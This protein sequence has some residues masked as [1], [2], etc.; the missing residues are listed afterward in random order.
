MSPGLPQTSG[1][2]IVD[3]IMQKH[4]ELSPP[5]QQAV[6]LS[7]IPAMA[8]TRLAPTLPPSPEMSPPDSQAI[9]A[10]AQTTLASPSKVRGFGP[11]PGTE[12][13]E[14]L[15]M[16]SPPD[17]GQ[18]TPL[19][20][21]I[22]RGVSLGGLPSPSQARGFG[23][24]PGSPEGN[25]AAEL[26]RLQQSPSG[27]GGIRNPWA[28]HGLQILDALG[29]AF[30]P[31]V[32]ANIPGTELHHRVLLHQ[33][34]GNVKNDQG[35]QTARLGAENTAAQTNL[36]GAQAAHTEAQTSQLENPDAPPDDFSPLPTDQGIAAFNKHTGTASPVT[37]NGKPAQSVEKPEKTAPQSIHV[38]PDGHVIAVHT[39][40]N[41]K[42]SAEVVYQG[43]PKQQTDVRPLEINGEQHTVLFDKATGNTIK[44]LGKTGVKPPVVNVNAGEGRAFQE[45]ERGRGLLDKAEDKY[46]QSSA[47]ADEL[48]A[49]ID[50]ARAGNK[51][52]A[53]AS[54][55][56]GTLAIVGSQGVKRINR[57]E[58]E[59]IQGAGSL[60][61]QLMGKVGKLTQGQ[62]IPSDIQSD[63]QKL[64]GLLKKNA[65]STYKQAHQ[66]AVKRYGLEGEEPLPEPGGSAPTPAN[67][68]Y[69]VGASYGGMKY[70]GGDPHDEKS[71]KK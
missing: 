54:P 33:A 65:Y 57:T 25:N 20:N 39:D 49:F 32:A 28:R 64:A 12:S 61:D 16:P 71:W 7:R 45:K 35:A 18:P 21:P 50:A 17:P 67:N 36:A 9:P 19:A 63:F 22:P 34:E 27:I 29:T 5:A 4:P 41:G 52:A 53:Q 37:V 6:G 46:R 51:V 44:D 14:G 11:L 3:E 66:S 42:S 60:F 70:M 15:S 55:L 24:L 38:L 48:S 59:G 62:P 26:Q 69:R 68:P 13:T 30:A 10:A 40:E 47:S 8:E 31:N 1:Q 58:L 23:P 2:P 56:E 43:D